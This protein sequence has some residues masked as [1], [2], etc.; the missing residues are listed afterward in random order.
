MK[1]RNYKEREVKQ[2]VWNEEEVGG[3]YNKGEAESR[4]IQIDNGCVQL[5]ERNVLITNL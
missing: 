1:Y 3:K 2:N 4:K 5:R